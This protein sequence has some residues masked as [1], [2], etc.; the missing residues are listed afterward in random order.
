MNEWE[1]REREDWADAEHSKIIKFHGGCHLCTQQTLHGVDFCQLCR[2]FD[3][4]WKLPNLSNKP[5]R[6][7]DIIRE[8]IKKRNGK[9]DLDLPTE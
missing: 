1:D 6:P 7:A 2:Y 3:K 8:E 5:P 4:Q 9:K